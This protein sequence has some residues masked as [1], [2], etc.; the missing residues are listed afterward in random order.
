MS[1]TTGS[2]SACAWGARCRLARATAMVAASPGVALQG[3]ADELAQDGVL[4]GRGHPVRGAERRRGGLGPVEADG[5]PA[6]RGSGT[7]RAVPRRQKSERWRSQ[8]T[9][10]MRARSSTARRRPDGDQRM[11][12]EP[13]S[14]TAARN[15]MTRAQHQIPRATPGEAL[16]MTVLLT[17]CRQWTCGTKPDSAWDLPCFTRAGYGWT[18]VVETHTRPH[19]GTR[20]HG[21]GEA[22]DQ[23]DGGPVRRVWGWG[24][25]R[26]DQ[27]GAHRTA[28][29][30]P[31]DRPGARAR[32]PRA[33][34]W[35]RGRG[36]G[37]RHSTRRPPPAPPPA[38]HSSRGRRPPGSPG[39]TPRCSGGSG[40]DPRRSPPGRGRQGLQVPFC[41]WADSYL[42]LNMHAVRKAVK[43]RTPAYDEFCTSYPEAVAGGLSRQPRHQA[44]PSAARHPTRPRSGRSRWGRRHRAPPR[45]G[46]SRT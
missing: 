38:S 46:C 21:V 31:R 15:L 4:E 8:D 29:Q 22:S 30:G 43:P 19:A 7:H 10:I 34:R 45:R 39:D 25:G 1:P 16:G 28:G 24:V 9:P 14:E 12:S 17:A 3:V 11:S 26:S 20:A 2:G 42:S 33:R 35:R 44:L 6:S 41:A 27:G 32:P 13:S 37:R 36:Q 5:T 40:T 23:K 18:P